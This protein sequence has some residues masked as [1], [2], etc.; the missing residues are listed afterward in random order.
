M[1]RG[2]DFLRAL[3]SLL[4]RERLGAAKRGSR[5]RPST[6]PR[7]PRLCLELLED[8]LTPKVTFSLSGSTLLVTLGAASDAATITGT[9]TAGSVTASGTGAKTQ[10]FT[11]LTV[12]TAQNAGTFTGQSVTF[13]SSGTNLISLTGAVSSTGIQSVI[14][15]TS[16]PLAAGSLT[17]SGATSGVQ[18][19]TQGVRT[20]GAQTY[21]DAVT[22]GANAT[23]TSTGGGNIKLAGT[24]NGGFALALNTAG[25]TTLGGAVGSGTALSSLTTDAAGSTAIN[26]GSVRTSGA[27]AYN[28]PVTLGAATTLT[29]TGTGV[30]FNSTVDSSATPWDLTVTTTSPASQVAFN[31]AVGGA[32]PLKSLTVNNA[33]LLAVAAAAST[34]VNGA[35]RQQG[36]GPVQ[37]AGNATT[38]GGAVNFAAPVTLTGPVAIATAGGNVS[39]G[40][41][42]DGAQNLTL[43]AGAGNVSFAGAVGSGTRLGALTVVSAANVTE[44]AGLKA[45]SLTQSAGTGTTAL[46]GPVDTNGAAGVTLTSGAIALNAPLNTTGGGPVTFTNAGPLTIA[47]GANI[48]AAGPV[49]QN[50]AGAVTTAGNITT[51]GANVSFATAVTLTGPVA[52]NTAGGGISFGGTLDGAQ[53]LTLT[54]GAGNVSFVGA[55]GSGAR[56]GAVAVV[57]AANVTE[58]AG[59]KAASLTQSAG[60][61]TTALN[62][63]VD[64]NGAAGV[65]LTTNAILLQAPL[66]TTG[67]GAVT[68]TNAGPLTI[69]AG[70]NI[71]ATGAVT[72][73]GA[74]PV[75]TAG[76][77]TTTG[78]PISFATAVTLTGPVAL[79]TTNGGGSPGGAAVSFGGAILGGPGTNLTVSAG[80]GNITFAGTLDGAFT[81][82]ANSGGTTTF[83]GDVGDTTPL[84]RVVTDAAG[85]TVIR[86]AMHAT[87]DLTFNDPVLLT[88][89]V[90]LTDTGTGITF[91]STVDSATDG[92][93][94][95]TTSS[96]STTTFGGAIGARKDTA[97][98]PIGRLA[99]LTGASGTTALNGGEVDTTGDQTF[100]GA[101]TLGTQ[102]SFSAGGVTT[103]RGTVTQPAGTTNVNLAI[104]S[105]GAD[106]SQAQVPVQLTFN[107]AAATLS[108]AVFKGGQNSTKFVLPLGGTGTPGNPNGFSGGGGTPPASPAVHIALVV[109]GGQNVIDLSGAG[110]PVLNKTNGTVQNVGVTL[111]LNLTN[112]QQQFVFQPQLAN[113]DIGSLVAPNLL[114]SDSQD[115]LSLQGKFQQVVVSSGAT[116][117]AAPSG[118]DLSTGA[119]VPGTNLVLEGSGNTVYGAPGATIQAFS[120]NNNVVQSF[121]ET[122]ANAFLVAQG[123]NYFATNATSVGQFFTAN[124]APVGQFFTANGGAVGQFF[125]A[126]PP[127][128]AQ[129]F[130]T[131]AVPVGQFFAANVTTV[132]TYFASNPAPVG[133]YFAANA[134][135]VGQFFTVNTTAVGSYFT[136][137]P[138]P[139]GNYFAANPI[140]V[141]QFFGANPVPVG[142]F[143]TAN[144]APVGQFFAANPTPVGSYFAANA[145]PVGQFFAVNGGAVGQFFTANVSQVGT[146]FAANPAPV[147][148]YFAANVGPVGQFFTANPGPVGQ[149]FTAN[150]GPVGQFFGVNPV[151]VGQFFTANPGPVGQFFSANAAAA[152]TYF[153]ANAGPVGQFFGANP[154]PVGQFFTANPG[155]VGQ[156]FSANAATAGSYFAANPGLLGNFFAT[157]SAPLGQFFTANAALVGNFFT[158]DPTAAA[159][160]FTAH[161]PVLGQFF[162]QNPGLAGQF[163]A[164]N[165]ALAVQF[166]AASP[167]LAGQFF[168]ANP[169]LA[170]QFFAANPA[171]AVQ[172]FAASPTLAGQFF[173]ANPTLA[174]QFFAQNP[175]LAGQFF[176]ANPN[177]VGQFFA[178]N[179]GLAGQFF[180]ANPTLAGQFFAQ[181]PGLAGQFFAANPNLVG[182]FFAANPTLAGQF[183]GQNP[184]LLGQFFTANPTLAGQFFAQN[185]GLAGQFFTANPGLVAQFFAANP[186]LVGQ[187]FAA[188]PSA[189]E[190]FFISNP[191][192]LEQFLTS[193]PALLQQ[194]LT[195]LTLSLLRLNV[196]MA[197]SG[198]EASGGFLSTFNLG[199]GGLFT[200]SIT[201]GQ[202]EMVNQA[203]ANNVALS[204]YFLNVT[205]TGGN[206]VVAGGL[207]G[208]FTAA[209]GGTNRFVVEDPTLLGVAPDTTINPA[210]SQ[211]GGT[212]TGSGGNDTTYFVGGG[213][214]S[215]FGSVVLNETAPTGTDVLDF[216]NLQGGGINLDLSQQGN[217][218]VVT[219][220]LSLTLP[221]APGI[222]NVIGSPGSDTILGN[223]LDNVLQGAAVAATHPNELPA[224]PPAAWSTSTPPTQLVYLDFT[225]FPAPPAT[226]VDPETGKTLTVS[227]TLH[228][229]NGQYS[230]SDPTAI[231]SR[232]QALFAP[233]GNLVQFTLTRP[234]AGPY[235]TVLFNDTPV[236]NGQPSPGGLSSEIDFRN[237]NRITTVQVDVNGFLGFGP[238]QV[239]DSDAA[240]VNLSVE[241]TAHELE[242][243]LGA[244]HP[245]AF[246]PVGFGISN[247]PGPA[248]YFPAYPGLVGAFTTGQHVIASPA[249]VGSTLAEAASGQVSIGER[250][251]VKLAFIS[252]GTVVTGTRVDPTA[253]V[254]AAPAQSVNLALVTEGQ[255]LGGTPAGAAQ[256]VSAQPVSL[257]TLSV[258]NPIPSGFDAGKTFDVAAVD[259]TGHLGAQPDFYTF[260]GQAGDLM[261]FEVMSAGLTRIAQPFDSVLYV[262]GPD[263]NLVAWNDDQFEPSDSAVTDLT[264]PATGTYTVEV[265]SYQHATGKPATPGDYELFLY[266]SATYNATSGNDVLE[267]Q[268]GNDT[269]IAGP[270]R[271]ILV[272]GTGSNLLV[273]GPSDDI[274]IAGTTSYDTNFADLA[275]IRAEWVR[276]DLSYQNRVNDLIVGG[277]GSSNVVNGVPILLFKGSAGTGTV[278]DNRS[279]DTLTGGPGQDLFYANSAV[280][281]DVI[282]DKTFSEKVV[283]LNNTAGG[284]SALQADTATG[285]TGTAGLLNSPADLLSGPQFVSVQED[286]GSAVPAAVEARVED[287]LAYWNSVVAPQGVS[288]TEVPAGSGA[289][290]FR[291][292]LSPTSVLGGA[293]DGVLGV[294]TADGTITLVTGWNWYTGSAPAQIGANQYDFETIVTHELGHALGLGHSTDATSVMYPYLPPGAVRRSL[295]ASDVAVLAADEDGGPKPLRAAPAPAAVG[296]APVPGGGTAA[297]D[298]VPAVPNPPAGDPAVATLVPPPGR[299]LPLV[300]ARLLVGLAGEALVLLPGGV[301]GGSPPAAGSG[302][303]RI[304]M[305]GAGGLPVAVPALALRGAP[306]PP[307]ASAR[308][309]WAFGGSSLSSGPNGY[310]AD[311]PA[312]ATGVALAVAMDVPHTLLPVPAAGGCFPCAE[313]NSILSGGAGSAGNDPEARWSGFLLG[314]LS[315]GDPGDG[316]AAWLQ[317]LGCVFVAG[318]GLG[319]RPRE[320]ER[321]DRPVAVMLK[322]ERSG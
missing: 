259:V 94:G 41:T 2:K 137:N 200:E 252:G 186:S 95:L 152:G 73:N 66:N 136:A 13:T 178:Q 101:V 105:G 21:N 28:D 168:A 38:A 87:G 237:L 138:T 236:Q 201:P 14:F 256:A 306:S 1:M 153:T 217:Q 249:S 10:T 317:A 107:P 36:A 99:S 15:S 266:R 81:L 296:L 170:G 255:L 158:T 270:D 218:Q 22:L 291:I 163:F 304:V 121:N 100:N 188:D 54:A 71:T 228:N 35:F 120:G 302:A 98:K 56:L 196:T 84:V 75:S 216:S 58:S 27:Q 223:G 284:T 122:A 245:D 265:D 235:E 263:G 133:V 132:G 185:P 156:F 60:T 78:N 172:F 90:T 134:G 281:Q 267:G 321:G 184:A 278:F 4:N 307:L 197:G 207:L 175:G 70:A 215:Q 212:F 135:P 114:T 239:P 298:L 219:P 42:L 165:P 313:G 67:G 227:E 20:S 8:R 193:N 147:G 232:L 88:G 220:G 283:N 166:F 322:S 241:V 225:D 314:G 25:V 154:V 203:I 161:I 102:T 181:N 293:A 264:L 143:F 29:S 240:F 47:A 130:A 46:N 40:G 77:V 195:Q 230:S 169:N 301:S 179:P 51:A 50:G 311:P 110:L 52:V 64:T 17:E 23:L 285:T 72:Q 146:Y 182:Q 167:S 288:L 221:S 108:N 86:G 62:G 204:N 129:F 55:V 229:D 80:A 224:V 280:L 69:A 279:L 68:F 33:G 43:A 319:S 272:G 282:T 85:T 118:Y 7:R 149:Y 24:V 139:V 151:P 213:A 5:H 315:P 292:H 277:K 93:Y 251:A 57:S 297:D 162:A 289:A 123:Q 160:F 173:A 9:S 290:D 310:A 190:Q 128:A 140:P 262:Y 258:P 125:T 59:L 34:A 155:P 208:N 320:R 30:T 194:V 65:A 231:L 238:N 157:T 305:N 19:N 226:V 142:Q 180:A 113:P 214:G 248:G 96:T 12:I 16:T 145:G 187:F 295:A 74:G 211:Y 48:T 39:F 31:Q 287:A 309:G 109:S 192:L 244:R 176:A 6:R 26:G 44:A 150:A 269:L 83:N 103:V 144:A 141:G 111:D 183:F 234:A 209:G 294:T 53:N 3:Q 106:V 191:T 11:G 303:A 205:F 257:Y 127:P 37:T 308:D 316:M 243:T 174:G 115:S 131:N 260:Q 299:G 300:P 247:P 45:A 312:P 119:A 268:G 148:A 253:T 177:L 202:M 18:I 233:F 189:L 199:S 246:G 32:H 49:T 63:P 97:G 116:L 76:N 222:T 92:A 61:G 104:T 89:N 254:P 286:D 198:N 82:T 318:V 124:P 171:L 274:L 159:T 261:N 112:G 276:T 164:A 79:N 273:G 91:K 275:A 271:S 242:H 126:N 210:L 117:F 250:E 206:N